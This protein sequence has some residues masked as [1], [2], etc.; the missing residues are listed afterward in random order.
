[1]IDPTIYSEDRRFIFTNWTNEVFTGMCGG[2][3]TTI[4]Q[5]KSIEFPMFKAYLFTK[6]LVDREMIKDKKEGSMSSQEARQEYEDKTI[7][8]I[9]AGKDSLALQNLKEKIK[10]EIEVEEG[11]KKTKKTPLKEKKEKVEVKEFEDLDK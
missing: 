6:H 2:E 8:E 1:M 10:E 4:E 11:K 9:T 7:V 5:G 3:L